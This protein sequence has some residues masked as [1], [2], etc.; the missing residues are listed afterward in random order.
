MR[1]AH[2]HEMENKLFPKW[3]SPFRVVETLE[4][5]VYRLETLDGGR[6]P[7]RGTPHT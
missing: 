7:E 2:Q 6:S 5:G 3:T 4:N 1:K